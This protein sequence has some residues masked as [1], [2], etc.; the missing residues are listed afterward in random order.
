METNKT[1]HIHEI[2]KSDGFLYV[3]KY[4]SSSGAIEE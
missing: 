1:H 3:V 4:M 2:S